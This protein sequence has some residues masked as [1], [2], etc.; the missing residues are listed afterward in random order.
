[1]AVMNAKSTSLKQPPSDSDGISTAQITEKS[2]L[3]KNLAIP[4]I[5]DI[6]GRPIGM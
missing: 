4:P 6:F 2:A 5:L 3:Y 1:M